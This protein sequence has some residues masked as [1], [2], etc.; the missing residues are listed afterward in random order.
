MLL[1]WCSGGGAGG[2]AYRDL[3]QLL[4]WKSPLPEE[5]VARM[6]SAE[7]TPPSGK[8]QQDG[9]AQSPQGGPSQAPPTGSSPH[10]TYRTSSQ[11]VTK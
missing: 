10:L 9:T 4:N 6:T 3:V 5:V 8:P 7:D 2:V 11:I 1:Q